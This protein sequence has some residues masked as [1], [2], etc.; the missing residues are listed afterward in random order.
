MTGLPEPLIYTVHFAQHYSH[1][2]EPEGRVVPN[3]WAGFKRN[4]SDTVQGNAKRQC[5]SQGHSPSLAAGVAQ[6]GELPGP[7]PGLHGLHGHRAGS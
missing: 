6:P 4:V 7:S 3:S 5:G 1:G 2:G